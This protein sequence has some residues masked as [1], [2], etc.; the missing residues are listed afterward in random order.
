MNI[1]SSLYLSFNP[2]PH[3][4]GRVIRYTHKDPIE[5]NSLSR[6]TTLRRHISKSE[7]LGIF[8]GRWVHARQDRTLTLLLPA[9][10]RLPA[11]PYALVASYGLAEIN[12]P[13]DSLSDLDRLQIRLRSHNKQRRTAT[14]A[15][16]ELSQPLTAWLGSTRHGPGLVVVRILSVSGA[17][18]RRHFIKGIRRSCRR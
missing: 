17:G 2:L 9:D 16:A 3:R 10:V 7:L 12:V 5:E 18:L 11:D 6:W 4:T 13:A 15:M 8:I 1:S 14:P